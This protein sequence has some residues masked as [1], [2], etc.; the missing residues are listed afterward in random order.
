MKKVKVLV[1]EYVVDELT[2]RHQ[3]KRPRG[4][5]DKSVL[6]GMYIVVTP[7]GEL[8]AY[9]KRPKVPV[10]GVVMSVEQQYRSYGEDFCNV[11]LRLF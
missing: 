6:P 11:T 3:V 10:V 7:K 1:G 5:R 8:V 9:D 4:S 2:T